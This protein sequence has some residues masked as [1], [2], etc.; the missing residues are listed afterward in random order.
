MQ[1]PSQLH[2]NLQ[3]YER[4]LQDFRYELRNSEKYSEYKIGLLVCN[5]SSSSDIFLNLQNNEDSRT[6]YR[7]NKKT[8]LDKPC[9]IVE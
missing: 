6:S 2:H 5:F 3:Q 4:A 7:T 8:M 9:W 1:L